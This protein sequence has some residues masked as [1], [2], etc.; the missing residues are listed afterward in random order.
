M[1]KGYQIIEPLCLSDLYSDP[2]HFEFAVTLFHWIV[3]EL[4]NE[5][6]SEI[7]GIDIDVIRVNYLG[8][9]PAIGISYINESKD[10]APLIESA[11]DHLVARKPIIDL[12]S[13]IAK[14]NIDWK[15]ETERLM[16]DYA[17]K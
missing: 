4:R 8:A 17:D 16:T 5:L 10:M 14:S 1:K 13:F 2:R 12:V 15:K 7:K 6:N 11:I 9:Y 3:D